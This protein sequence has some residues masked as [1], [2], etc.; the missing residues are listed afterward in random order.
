MPRTKRTKRQHIAAPNRAAML[1]SALYKLER[2]QE[3]ATIASLA[4]EVGLQPSTW[5]RNLVGWLVS[6]GYVFE[7]IEYRTLRLSENTSMEWLNKHGWRKRYFINLDVVAANCPE[8]YD[9]IA[10]EY[11]LQMGLPE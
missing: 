2:L 4:R 1:L 5:L 8:V 6:E 11:G 10:R 3:P 7:D 9:R